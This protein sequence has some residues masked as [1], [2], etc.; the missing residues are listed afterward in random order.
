MVR[1]QLHMVQGGNARSP[2]SMLGSLAGSAEGSFLAK[3]LGGTGGGIGGRASCG[4]TTIVRILA[5]RKNG[6]A[7]VAGP[8]EEDA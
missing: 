4:S 8:G 1:G 7:H 2:S 5:T 6:A 3:S